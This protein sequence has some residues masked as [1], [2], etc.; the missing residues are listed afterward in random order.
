LVF[1]RYD[2]DQD[3]RLGI[4][5]F[6]NQLLPTE[7]TIRDEVEHRDSA[8]DMTYDTRDCLVNVFRKCIDVEV[9]VEMLRQRVNQSMGISIR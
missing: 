9:E 2:S 6:T 5:E 1:D 7:N 4:W 3:G 8:Y